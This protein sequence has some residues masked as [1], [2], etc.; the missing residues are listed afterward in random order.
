MKRTILILLLTILSSFVSYSQNTEE[1]PQIIGEPADNYGK[2]SF[3]DESARLD[4]F[5]INVLNSPGYKGLMV[6]HLDKNVS[7]KENLSRLRKIFKH[8]KYRK[9]EENRII[10]AVIKDD[11]SEQTWLWTVP[12]EAKLPISESQ[13]AVLINGEEFQERVKTIFSNK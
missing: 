13:N 2:M 12:P 9:L 3:R 11:I 1:V 4:S 10:F 7:P 6:L 8:I 5:I